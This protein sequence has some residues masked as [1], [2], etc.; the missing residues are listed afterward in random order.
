MK[1][2]VLILF[3][4]LN[5]HLSLSAQEIITTAGGDNKTGAVSLHWTLGQIVT[6]VSTN[7]TATLFHGF[8]QST[9]IVTKISEVE[10]NYKINI[11]PNPTKSFL[12]I[13]IDE[14]NNIPL[15]VKILNLSGINYYNNNINQKQLIIDISKFTIGTYVV[16]FSE[17]NKIVSNY[18]V[19]IQ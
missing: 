17:K 11:Y 14:Q 10:L 5:I 16:Q 1:T 12:I 19:I 8:Q 18:K 3:I 6:G 4:S 15:N 7:G 9:I 13:E 2:I